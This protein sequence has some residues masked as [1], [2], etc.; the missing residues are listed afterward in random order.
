MGN[1]R[2]H[3]KNVYNQLCGVRDE[4]DEE[5]EE[6]ELLVN[7]KKENSIKLKPRLT[8]DCLQNKL[9][10]NCNLTLNNTYWESN[11]WPVDHKSDALVIMIY[12]TAHDSGFDY[13]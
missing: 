9:Y 8:G 11:L 1:I 10:L 7:Y 3:T 13:K 12:D 2:D 4:A 6:L 5:W